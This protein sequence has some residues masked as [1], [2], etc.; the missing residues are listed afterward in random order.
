MR[1]GF[2][3]EMWKKKTRR[4]RRTRHREESNIKRTLKGNWLRGE[5]T[6]II[7]LWNI[8]MKFGVPSNA[9]NFLTS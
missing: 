3:D 9:V 4:R 8:A 1:A 5:W 6:G 2:G 7:G